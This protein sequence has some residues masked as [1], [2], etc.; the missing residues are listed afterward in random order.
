MQQRGRTPAAT[1]I[2]LGVTGTPPR[3]TAPSSL[4][5]PERTLFIELV[6]SCDP[7]HFVKSDM[8]LLVSYV[9]AA[10]LVRSAA[11]RLSKKQDANTVA[12]WERAVRTMAMLA[13]RLRLAPQARSDPKTIAGWQAAQHRKSDLN[14][15]QDTANESS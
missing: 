11:A 13:T 12:T 3:L 14:P 10:L 9:Q 15:W 6:D 8:P 7:R 5:K 4:T 1:V 2:A